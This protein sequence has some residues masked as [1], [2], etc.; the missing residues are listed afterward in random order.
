[1]SDPN[2]PSSGYSSGYTGGTPPS[3]PHAQMAYDAGARARRQSEAHAKQ[4]DTEYQRNFGS[5]RQAMGQKG[6][7]ESPPIDVGE[8]IDDLI[9]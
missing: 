4:R 7:T 1:M 9:L 8:A 2:N 5:Q 6:R 3:D